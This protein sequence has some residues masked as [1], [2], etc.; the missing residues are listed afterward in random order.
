MPAKTLAVCLLIWG[1]SPLATL[2]QDCAQRVLSTAEDLAVA[3]RQ[4]AMTSGQNRQRTEEFVAEAARLLDE[5]RAACERAKTPIERNYA[6]AK[7]LVAQGNLDA[8][9]LFIKGSPF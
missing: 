1:M 5:A 8:A 2:A 9:R 4:M 6:I 7:I 3:K